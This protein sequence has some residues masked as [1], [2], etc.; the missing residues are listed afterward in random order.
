MAHVPESCK[1]IDL[2]IGFY[3]IILATILSLKIDNVLHA[4]ALHTQFARDHAFKTSEQ[5]RCCPGEP[6]TFAINAQRHKIHFM[7]R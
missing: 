3:L 2:S 5:K 1:T 6:R 4:R 7:L